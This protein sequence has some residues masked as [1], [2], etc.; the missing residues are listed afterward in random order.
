MKSNIPK[1]SSALT[2]AGAG[3][4]MISF[5]LPWM[6]ISCM[7]TDSYSGQDFG[8]IYWLVFA[9]AAAIFVAYVILNLFKRL[10]LL[11]RVVT[12]AVVVSLAVIIYGCLEISDGKR[13]LLFKVG[14]EDVDLR[15]QSGGYG[16]ILGYLVAGFGAWLARRRDDHQTQEPAQDG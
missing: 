15:L 2:P 7:G 12:A 13:V 5:F 4:I 11:W 8:G 10:D 9:M 14:P 1:K 3:L 16:T 6:R